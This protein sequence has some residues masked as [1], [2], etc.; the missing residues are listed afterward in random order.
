[1][2]FCAEGNFDLTVLIDDAHLLSDEAFEHVSAFAADLPS[3]C[4]VV[5]CRRSI[6]TRRLVGPVHP[7]SIDDLRMTAA[8]VAAVIGENV[9]GGV[10]DDVLRVTAGWPA[11]VAIAAS[12]LRDDP[13]WSPS[14]RSAGTKLLGALIGGLIGQT[15]AAIERLAVLPLLDQFTADTVAGPGAFDAFRHSGLPYRTE[16][17]WITIPDSIRDALLSRADRAPGLEPPV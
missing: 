1:M 7:L 11:A 9:A 2:S 13:S 6:D 8:E 12:R 5:L 14:Q 16:G 10:V 3:S 15:F 4:R 17:E